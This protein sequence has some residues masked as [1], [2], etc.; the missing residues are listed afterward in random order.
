MLECILSGGQF[1]A[2]L[3][4]LLAASVCGLKTKGHIPKGYKTEK[5]LFPS[6]ARFGLVETKSSGY[7]ERTRLNVWDSDGT[8][9][10]ARNWNS[11]GTVKTQEICEGI[12]KPFFR[13]MFSEPGDVI[14]T[15]P[16][17]VVEWIQR[18][19]IHI[20]N[21]AGN[22]ESKAPGI[23]KWATQFLIEVFTEVVKKEK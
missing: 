14:L 1:G 17:D 7:E 19:D 12:F 5:G 8:L 16:H 2:D 15:I 22:R 23:Q 10:L 18:E 6:L 21:I 4:G 3:A 20:L 13:V 9:L 11:P